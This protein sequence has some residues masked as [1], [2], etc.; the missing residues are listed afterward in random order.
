MRRVCVFCESWASGGIESF[1]A[2]LLTNA[3]ISD[4]EIDLVAACVEESIFTAPLTERGICFYE[5]SG[6]RNRMLCNKRMFQKL[7]SERHYDVI[8]ANI[9]HGGSLYYLSLAKK[10]GVPVRIAHSHNAALR[11]GKLRWMKVA[12]HKWASRRYVIC[13]TDLWAASKMAADFMFPRNKRNFTTI[14]IVPNGIDTSKFAF[15][16]LSESI[17]KRIR[18]DV[19]A[20]DQF[21][22]GHIGRL[23]YQKNQIFLLR[24]FAELLKKCPSSKLLLVGDGEDRVRLEQEADVLRIKDRVIFWGMTDHAEQ[25]L[26]AMDVFVFPSVF[27]G[28]GIVAVEAQTSGLPV[29]CSDQI[30]SE[31]CVMTSVRR[32]SLDA[33]LEPWVTA[34]INSAGTIPSRSVCASIVKKCGF[35]IEDVVKEVEYVYQ[36]Q[37][38]MGAIR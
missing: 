32:L 4:M 25:L 12:I 35:D 28:L 13:A 36:K 29:V 23:C 22:I 30:P 6:N 1:L 21:I 9:F 34:I 7:L 14:K 37:E 24:V 3:D 17:R 19:R 15:S 27:E 18:K 20:T 5:L 10:M 38:P 33:G 26:W 31:A 8:H 2:S 16:Q 11:K